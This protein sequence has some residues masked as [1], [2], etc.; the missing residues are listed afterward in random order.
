V[1]L[2][3]LFEDML[4]QRQVKL[5]MDVEKEHLDKQKLRDALRKQL[6]KIRGKVNTP[7]EQKAE[8]KAL[9]TIVKPHLKEIPNYYDLLIPLEEKAKKRQGK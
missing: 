5:G 9:R 8:D 1:R 7:A 4:N 6:N 3:K 2:T